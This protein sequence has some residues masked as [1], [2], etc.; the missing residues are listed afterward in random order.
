MDSFIYSIPT[1]IA[2]GKGQIKMLP[3]FVKEYGKKVLLIYGGGSIKRTGIY[4]TAINLFEENGITFTELAGVE[5]NPQIATVRRG[6]ELCRRDGIEVLVPIG[7]GSTIDCAKAISVGTFY[8]G[9]AWDIVKDNSLITEALPI[10]SVL[11][12]A[13]TGSEMDS[14]SVIS[15][16]SECDKA[17]INDDILYPKY[18]ILDPT[19]TY[20]VPPYQTAAGVADIMS[21]IFEYY[22]SGADILDIEKSMMDAILKVCV[23]YGPIAV[24]EP[25]NE[26]ARENLMWAASWAINGFIACGNNSSWPCHAMEYQLTNKYHV[27]HGHGM[28]IIDAAWMKHI[29]GENTYG[30]FKRYAKEVFQITEGTDHEI[31][32]KAI[33]MTETV[34]KDMGLTLTLQSIGATSKDDI[35][36]MA[37]KAVDE[38]GLSDAGNMSLTESDVVQIYESCY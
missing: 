5:P 34:Y 29:L 17:E 30:D 24:K 33:E 9:D 23:T 28:A 20:T 19:Y 14:S 32:L 22:F 13:A 15:N 3:E 12:V 36:A 10:V 6:I 38:F 1:K 7:G 4:D 25:D 27:T 21:H 18:S 35:P 37:K 11:T 8:D 2:F 31:G 16:D 26:K